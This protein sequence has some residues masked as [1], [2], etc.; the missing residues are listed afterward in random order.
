MRILAVKY[1]LL[2]QDMDRAVTF[3]RDAVGLE[4][5]FVSPW[6][7]ELAMAGAV[8]A[9][10]GG[11]DGSEHPTGLGFEVDDI[12]AATE[13]LTAAGGSLL[14]SPVRKPQE[15]IWLAEMADPEGNTFALSQRLESTS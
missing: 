14:G 15:G 13:A 10:H 2:A 3:Y 5:R 11:G 7:S 1:T 6:W 9:L 4:A 8:V 12:H